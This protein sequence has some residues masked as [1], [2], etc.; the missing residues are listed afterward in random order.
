MIDIPA[1]HFTLPS[2]F[3]PQAKSFYI[4]LLGCKP[5]CETEQSI[6]LN[7]FGHQLLIVQVDDDFILQEHCNKVDKF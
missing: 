4:D 1:F 6:L 3:L 5:T 2:N 7:F